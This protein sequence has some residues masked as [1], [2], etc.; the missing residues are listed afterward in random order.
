MIVKCEAI[1][2]AQFYP[3]LYGSPQMEV[4]G[5]CGKDYMAVPQS[6]PDLDYLTANDPPINFANGG[7][8]AAMAYGPAGGAYLPPL[9]HEQ[10]NTTYESFIAPPGNKM[11]VNA[12]NRVIFSFFPSRCI[13]LL[14]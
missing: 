12:S 14:S 4:D 8:I 2:G 6:N 3:E 11:K 5:L 13:R 10:Y 7:A 1:D 9:S